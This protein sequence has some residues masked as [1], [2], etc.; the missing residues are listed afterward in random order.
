MTQH[1]PVQRQA[2]TSIALLAVVALVAFLGS[3]ATIPN[4]EGWYAEATKVPWNPPNSVFGPAW[5]VLYVLIAAAG[6][7]VWRSGWRASAPNAARTSLTLFTVQL[8]LNA[9]WTPV[10]FAGYPVVGEAAW[11]VALAIMVALVGF[12]IAFAF[13]AAQWSKVAAW[14]MV[15]YLLWLLFATSLNIGI[16]ALN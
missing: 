5:S 9:A 15:P 11:W 3:Q 13:S 4:T 6:W 16:I 2:A 12:V 10:F 14:L 1:P 8:V 7:L